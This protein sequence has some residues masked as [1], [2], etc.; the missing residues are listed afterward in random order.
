M[1]DLILS[2]M[3]IAMFYSWIHFAFIQH[4]KKY[5]KRTNWEKVV[6]W[7]AMVSFGLYLIGTLS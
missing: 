4:T 2:I 1:E 7:T 3:G 5:D 6:T